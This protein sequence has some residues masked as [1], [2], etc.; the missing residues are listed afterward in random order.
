MTNLKR[1]TCFLLSLLTITIPILPSFGQQNSQELLFAIPIGINLSDQKEPTLS[2][3]VEKIEYVPLEYKPECALSRI[4][5]LIATEKFFFIFDNRG[6]SQFD[7]SGIYIRSIGK[8]GRGPGEY[9]GLRDFDVDESSQRIFILANYV[10]LIFIYDFQGKYIQ[11]IRL[12]DDERDAI[13]ISRDG[14]IVT[15]TGAITKS[16]LST[17]I[18]NQQGKSLI[19][20]YSRCYVSDNKIKIAKTPNIVYHYNNDIFFKEGTNDTVYKIYLGDVRPS[21]TYNLGKFKPPLNYPYED[22]VKY[23]EIFKICES[24]KKI[25]TFFFYKGTIGVSVYDKVSKVIKSSI[26]QDLTNRGI[27]NDMDKGAN[28]S[29]SSVP[30][31]LKT[32]QN[33]FL[34][35]LEPNIL[36]SYI[37]DQRITGNFKKVIENF[38]EGDNPVVMVIKPK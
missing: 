18:L 25:V 29:L 31:T 32:N 17:E 19:K 37:G 33:E 3:L 30:F 23:I 2:E 20:F 22:K 24:D 5:R 9:P 4:Q 8:V 13:D 36:K 35:V 1:F 26:Q 27:K 16:L 15:Q 14:L 7:R 11:S 10:R 34:Q 38:K 28:F 21:Y 12:N 6:I